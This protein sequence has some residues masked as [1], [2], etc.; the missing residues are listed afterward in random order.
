MV[1]WSFEGGFDD[2]TETVTADWLGLETRAVIFDCDVAGFFF[3][4]C[5]FFVVDLLVFVTVLSMDL[6][7]DFFC[8]FSLLL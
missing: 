1:V 7:F 6:V 5:A 8:W 4:F 3:A 2:L